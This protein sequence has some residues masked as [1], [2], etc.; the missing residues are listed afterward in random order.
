MKIR[1]FTLPNLITLCGL[2]CG[3]FAIVA[4]LVFNDLTSAFWLLAAAVVFDF[5]DGFTARLLRC[6]S[7]V[8]V[9]LDSLSDMVSSGFL[10]AA[11]LY[12]LYRDAASVWT[13]GEGLQIAGGYVLFVVT[14]FS[15][16]RLAKFNVDTTQSTE[17]C[18]LPTPACSL[19]FVSL[20]M[21][22]QS[23][24]IAVPREALVGAAL[25]MSWLLISPIRMF[26][27]K[28]H[29]F[30]WRGNGL[31]YAFIALSIALLALLRVWAVPSIIVLYILISVV[32]SLACR[33]KC[34]PAADAGA[35]N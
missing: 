20:G 26:A 7:E 23:E 19:F 11:V 3:S 4:T 16:L 6:G 29:G 21:L 15:A 5:L 9:Q 10:P 12:V 1:L 35:R 8:G 2:L 13:W 14:V 18:G 27:L 31:R 28:F 32:R 17:F 25:I 24:G 30:G 34:T 22:V 33:N